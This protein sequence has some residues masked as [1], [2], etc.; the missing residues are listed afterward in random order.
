MNGNEPIFIRFDVDNFQSKIQDLAIG[1]ENYPN[2]DKKWFLSK[3][4]IDGVYRG[5]NEVYTVE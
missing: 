5:V 1:N 3:G 4:I 2:A